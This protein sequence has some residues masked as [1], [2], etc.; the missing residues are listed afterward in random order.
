ML[1]I[2]QQ[3]IAFNCFIINNLKKSEKMRSFIAVS[4]YVK[5]KAF[6]T[7]PQKIKKNFLKLLSDHA[8]M[9]WLL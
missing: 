1:K 6:K 7:F 8:C 3:K 9:Y 4:L 2:F 5:I